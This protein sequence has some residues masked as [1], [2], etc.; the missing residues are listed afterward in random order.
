MEVGGVG[1]HDGRDLRRGPVPPTPADSAGRGP[2]GT[3][4]AEVE[5]YAFSN[6]ERTAAARVHADLV[7]EHPDNAVGRGERGPTPAK[8]A[9]STWRLSCEG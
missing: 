6:G 7:H 4:K 2:A 1:G 3:A 9:W 8:A 5:M